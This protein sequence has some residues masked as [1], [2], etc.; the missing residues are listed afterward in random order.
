MVAGAAVGGIEIEL[1]N[2]QSHPEHVAQVSPASLQH[3]NHTWALR[4]AKDQA[5][6]INK[7]RSTRFGS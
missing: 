6:Y 2:A 3:E 1:Y 4:S 7:I 5:L